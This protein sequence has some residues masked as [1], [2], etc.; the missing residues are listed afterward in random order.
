MTHRIQ[1]SISLRRV[2]RVGYAQIY[3]CSPLSGYAEAALFASIFASSGILVAMDMT[4][5]TGYA[6]AAAVI[7]AGLLLGQD[8]IKAHEERVGE[9]TAQAQ[10]WSAVRN[11]VRPEDMLWFETRIATHPSTRANGQATNR[12]LIDTFNLYVER[13]YRDYHARHGRVPG[14]IRPL[15]GTWFS[16]RQDGAPYRRD[17]SQGK[18]YSHAAT[19][20]I[21]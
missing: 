11:S 5:L 3:A 18:Q 2:P 15:P 7:T 8:L 10:S 12:A 13:R 4:G 6:L 9:R 17:S 16:R 1:P 14:L 19:S 20:R 21:L